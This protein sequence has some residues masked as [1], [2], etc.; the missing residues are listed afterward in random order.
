MITIPPLTAEILAELCAELGGCDFQDRH[1]CEFLGSTA[2]CDVQAAPGNGKTTLIAAK[3]ALL[4]RTW[5]SR[6]EGVCVISHTNAARREV[7]A[8]LAS[9]PAASAFLSY[10][11][12]VG[13]VTAF[14]DRF[15]ALPYLRGLG[16]PI[17]R[18]DDDVFGAVA[19]ARYHRKPTLVAAARMQGRQHQVEGWIT[20]MELA[21]GFEARVGVE[22][23]R[24]KIRTRNRQ[25]G[26]HTDSGREL[27]E[28]KAELV[29]SGFYRFADMTAIATQ[30]VEKCPTLVERLRKRFPLVLLDEA[31]DTN[32]AQLELLNR[33]FSAGTAYQ[34]LGDQNQTLYED[35]EIP[36]D[37]YWRANNHAIPLNQTRRFGSEIASFASR[38]TARS[39]Q[40]IEG[41]VGQPNRRS[42][43]LFCRETIRGVLPEY[44]AQVRAHWGRALTSNHDV[45]AVASRHNLYRDT[46]GEWPKSLVDY[47]P[48][49]RSGVGR[50]QNPESL[51]AAL[52][53]ASV[54][55]ESG[56]GS[57][58]DIVD[59]IAIGLTELLRRHGM[60]GPVNERVN[61][62][63]LWRTLAAADPALPLRVRRLI[64]DNVLH[65]E[66]AWQPEAWTAFCQELHAL[67]GAIE[68]YNRAALAFVQFE[69][70]GA[71]D[72]EDAAAAQS[73]TQFSQDGVSVKLGSI[74]SVKGR[75][76][77]AILVVETEIWRGA[78]R[79]DR[80]M[81]LAAVL[82]HAL[83]IENRD[84]NAN[85]AL[86]SA[87][88]NVF[89]GV[90][91]PK[92][93]LALALRKEVASAAMI[94]AARAQGWLISDLTLA[95]Q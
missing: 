83:S 87:A 72:D 17:Q 34:R 3:L 33:L 8:K 45:W 93:V 21:V 30:A 48:E 4:S 47:C 2:S 63:T 49:Y 55:R 24:L 20:R 38:L 14:L 13:T 54:L 88:T 6:A 23:T 29:N 82:P 28:L 46:R 39:P 59:L 26:S 53:R 78:R 32:G 65:G 86:L 91:R 85:A 64:L 10:P 60:V 69:Q 19:L 70:Q 41:V 57:P 51:C 50:T 73:K 62:R 89:V 76:V 58:A 95:Q 15:L 37:E 84:F 40:Q 77:D 11:H 67:I 25:P 44:T 42:I 18:I 68:P 90:T 9:H 52:R 74:H 66:A 61:T 31:Q 36:Q 94:E 1:Q 12:F 7:E 79:E 92:H 75:T 80:V 22:P 27:E 56:S 81:D 5:T 35:D 16:W 43:I 71:Q